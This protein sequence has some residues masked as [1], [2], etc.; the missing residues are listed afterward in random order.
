MNSLHDDLQRKDVEFISVTN[1]SPEEIESFLNRYTINGCIGFDEDFSLLNELGF[2]F[3]PAV[4]IVDR[5]KNILWEGLPFDLD[6]KIIDQA[7]DGSLVKEEKNPF[8]TEV[9]MN[10]PE[11]P[12]SSSVTLGTE[13]QR[14]VMVFE[15]QP[16]GN[17]LRNIL[18]WRDNSN[19][20]VYFDNQ[21]NYLTTLDFSCSVDKSTFDKARF[22]DFC[23]DHLAT[24][25]AFATKDTFV[26]SKVIQFNEVDLPKL[27]DY[28]SND[29][30]FVVNNSQNE[31]ELRSAK[32]NDA[33]EFISS[34]YG[35]P[36][37]SNISDEIMTA[38]RYNFTIPRAPFED[39]PLILEE[40][41]INVSIVDGKKKD[42]IVKF[43]KK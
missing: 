20:F 21:P 29:T 39:L 31:T 6:L 32:L 28:S 3:I 12:D 5:D 17:V 43:Q 13:N 9:K 41:G 34:F 37:E 22:Y 35:L 24:G 36:L 4:A 8:F 26:D 11:N 18:S 33:F 10:P 7:I 38:N 25:L 27:M 30:A 19:Y 14:R 42:V 1:E 23:F 2:K 16:I 15:S 40:L